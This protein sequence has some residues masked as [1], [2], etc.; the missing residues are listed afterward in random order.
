MNDIE[1]GNC[2][3]FVDFFCGLSVPV[4][5]QRNPPRPR[6]MHPAFDT[7]VVGQECDG[8]QRVQSACQEKGLF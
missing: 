6:D 4:R 1:L 3:V 2:C 8:Y 5:G 7:R